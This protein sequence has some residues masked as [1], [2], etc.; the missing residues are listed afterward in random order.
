MSFYLHD[1][2]APED[3]LHGVVDGHSRG[4]AAAGRVDVKCDVRRW[5][6]IG[7]VK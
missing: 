2:R 3:S 6:G 5:V 7:E 1:K 4:H